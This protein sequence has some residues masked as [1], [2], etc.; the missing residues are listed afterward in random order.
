MKV[1]SLSETPEVSPT[2]GFEP[3]Y[4]DSNTRK[5]HR[6]PGSHGQSR[7]LEIAT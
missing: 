1:I 6:F 3:S 5:H 7:T 4:D 2:S